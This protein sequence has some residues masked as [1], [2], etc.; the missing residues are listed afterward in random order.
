MTENNFLMFWS[1]YPRQTGRRAAQMAYEYAL[2][3]GAV[4]EE[5]MAGLTK[6]LAHI[7]MEAI[8]FRYVKQPAAWLRDG[9]WEDE[10][11]LN[12]PRGATVSPVLAQWKGRLDGYRRNGF[13]QRDL[14]GPKP[15]E[16]ECKCPAELMDAAQI[17]GI[18]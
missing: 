18:M 10:Y 7:R 13:W 5:I 1:N 17:C 8:E 11:E 12:V 6:Y 15:G 4:H 2:L 3:T 14:W 16:P 9:N